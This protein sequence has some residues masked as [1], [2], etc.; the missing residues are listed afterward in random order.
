MATREHSETKKAQTV[1]RGL[2]KEKG[3][4]GSLFHLELHREITS[5]GHLLTNSEK[6]VN[7][8]LLT[9]ST[10]LKLHFVYTAYKLST[11]Y[12]LERSPNKLRRI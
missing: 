6:I 11:T 3:S 12:K 7:P 9:M 1:T 2:N 4:M 10:N 8:V 5:L